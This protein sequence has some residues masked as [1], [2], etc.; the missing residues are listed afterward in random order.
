MRIFK[1][2]NVETTLLSNW[3]LSDKINSRSSL[4]GTCIK[5]ANVNIGSSINFYDGTFV[6]FKG[7]IVTLD[8]Y[9]DSGVVYSNF[10]AADLTAIA[11]RRIVAFTV[12]NKTAKEIIE[13][14]ILPSLNEEG[15]TAGNISTGVYITKGVFNYLT[16][17]KSMDYL[18]NLS[19]SY[20][21]NIDKDF[22]LNYFAKGDYTAPFSIDLNTQHYNFKPSQNMDA[23]R[24]RQFVRGGKGYTSLQID[25]YPTSQP[26]GT[27]RDFI[28]RYKIG[29]KPTKLEVYS[30]G[31][32]TEVSQSD[33]GILNLDTEKKWY[34]SYDNNIIT[35]DQVETV[36]SSGKL[37]RMSYYGLRNI[38][39]ISDDVDEIENRKITEGFGSGIYEN[40]AV[41]KTLV[42]TEQVQQYAS[43]L[44]E[45]YAETKDWLSFTT[46]VD[47]LMAGQLIYINK[48]LFGIDA[49][50]LI[51]SVNMKAI[52]Y[53]TYQY[54]VKCLDGA[55]VGGWESY[56]KNLINNVNSYELSADEVLFNVKYFSE[57]IKYVSETFIY[58]KDLVWLND[59]LPPSDQLDIGNTIL[60]GY[61]NEFVES[62]EVT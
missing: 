54:D 29:K 2:N 31:V 53:N 15:V 49:N 42:S 48:P 30:G 43:G 34:Y 16:C 38:F 8:L 13:D 28:F 26:D 60:L 9:E 5:T 32:W 17:A 35:Q 23:Y 46:S 22:K 51:E 59:N 19:P 10:S 39:I 47:G 45:K 12:E 21:W 3:S 25:Q 36:L 44:L 62:I 11:D 4:N 18:V 24:N 55:S 40:M 33:I 52:N 41:E 56:F 37:I 1:V 57:M 14:Y 61:Y 50:Y 20:N 58:D 6:I 7:I 27:S